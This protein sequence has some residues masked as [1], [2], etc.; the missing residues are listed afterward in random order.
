MTINLLCLGNL[1]IDDIVLP[2]GTTRMACFGGDTIYASLAA[3]YWIDQVQF[4]APLGNDFPLAHL[5]KLSQSGWSL[6]GLPRRDVPSIRNWVIYE[7]DGRRTWVLRS[8]PGNFSSL[9]PTPADIPPAFQSPKA[10]LILAMDLKSQE[11]LVTTLKAKG[12]LIALDPQENYIYGNEARIF[13]ML[14]DVDIFFPSQIEI[15]RLLGHDN[16]QRAAQ[17][18]AD[19]GCQV[20]VI[21]MGGEGSLIYQK[22]TAQIWKIPAYPTT[23][24]DTTGAGDAYCGGFMAMYLDS[25]NLQKS[26]LA[27]TVSASFAV[28][29]FGLSH[30]FSIAREMAR[31]R[32]IH[33]TRMVGQ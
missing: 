9:S 8:D 7:N 28:E 19:I 30:M 22:S 14:S 24:I 31:D 33:I 4:V 6:Q 17:E 20:V 23:V 21:K 27:G 2:D 3:S 13:K 32:L 16:Y 25:G 10:A 18:F 26:G 15:S 11:Q 12:T 1:T 5:A 29:D